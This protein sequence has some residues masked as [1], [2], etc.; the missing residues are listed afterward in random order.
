MVLNEAS[1][2][3][4]MMV[5]NVASGYI[6]AATNS[7]TLFGIA[8][9]LMFLALVYVYL[10]VPES[11]PAEDI[12]QG[13]KLRE[14][15]RFGLVKDLVRTSVLRRDNFDR[16]FIWLTMIALTITIFNMEGE[17]TVNI[18]FMREQF[19]WTIKDISQFN[20]ARIVIQL[21]GS[22][23]GMILLRRVL[24]VSIISVA[25]LSLAACVLE[26]T[27]RATAKY[28]WEMYL[29]M[30]LGMMRGVLGPMCRAI[31]SHVAPATDVGEC[32]TL[33]RAL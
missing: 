15:F 3:A 6:Y 13:S 32:F 27:V 17:N 22:V 28:S 14:F 26:S 23:A 21:F 33:T 4:G 1:L 19:D 20:A 9:G 7:V 18:M 24:K 25:M 30:T 31:L 12:H 8:A 2:C 29:G 10:L 11:L 5:G 16:A